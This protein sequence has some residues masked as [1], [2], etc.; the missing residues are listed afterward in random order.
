[1]GKR[2]VEMNFLNWDAEC[3]HDLMTGNGFLITDPPVLEFEGGKTRSMFGSQSPLYGTS[4]SDDQELASRYRCKCGEFVGKVFRGSTCPKCQTVVE[5]KDVKPEVTGW[6]PLG[7]NK[8]VNPLFYRMLG[9]AIGEED[10]KDIIVCQQTVNRD[11]V[12]APLTDED[13]EYLNTSNPFYGIGLQD[14]RKRYYDVL[15][16][17]EKKKPGKKELVNFLRKNSTK[18]FTSYVPVYT[19]LLRQASVAGDSY[20]YTGIDRHINPLINLSRELGDC[21]DIDLSMIL[22]RIQSRV[23]AMWEINFSEIDKKDGFIRDQI[24]GGSINYSSRDVIIPDPTLRDNEV[25]ISYAAAH[26]LFRFPIIHHL[27]TTNG[28]TLSEANAIWEQGS[29]YDERIHKVIL[30]ILEKD[31][32]KLI[33]NRNPTLSKNWCR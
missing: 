16:W 8:V 13:R 14:F 18:V 22:N 21:T 32:P 27:M 5:F 24:S 19:P 4:I 20:Y 2:R 3:Y 11:G 25:D 6:I 12:R 10:F 28:I 9:S 7:P 26:V 29:V 17:T 1:M 23:N 15:D 31:R 33:V 30:Y